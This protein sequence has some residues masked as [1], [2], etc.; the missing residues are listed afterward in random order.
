M[1]PRTQALLLAVASQKVVLPTP[2]RGIGSALDDTQAKRRFSGRRPIA[3]RRG[4]RYAHEATRK[5]TNVASVYEDHI[6]LFLDFLGFSEASVQFDENR[7]VEILTLLRG[8]ADLR[9]EFEVKSQ[10]RDDGSSQYDVKPAV[11]TFSDHIVISYPIKRLMVEA[12]ASSDFIIL[13]QI[14]L[15]V[16][17][18]AA[19]AIKLGFLIRGGVA[20]GKLY[21][22][23]G[24]VF[25]EALVRAYK[26]ESQVAVYPRVIV[27]DEIAG[28]IEA[29]FRPWVK[30]DFDGLSCV[31][32][33]LD[34][35]LRAA[36]P[37]NEYAENIKVSYR[38]LLEQL[39]RNIER[40]KTA[41]RSGARAKWIWFAKQ[42]YEAMSRQNPQLLEPLGVS[43]DDLQALFS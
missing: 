29:R 4:L 24:V 32:Y 17:V 36:P 25:G 21:H 13:N 35:I 14:S 37:G 1:Q 27:S 8:I 6:V 34:T 19:S 22:A 33:F 7:Q 40:L 2:I 10:H 42:L 3:R 12:K 41:E 43:L 18:I 38:E 28:S 11:S 5:G 31:D 20:K 15:Y 16:G 30:K 23:D 9:S 26:L 39:K